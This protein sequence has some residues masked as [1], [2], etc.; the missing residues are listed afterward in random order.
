[1]ARLS[2]ERALEVIQEMDIPALRRKGSK[3]GLYGFYVHKDGV[4][5]KVQS[6]IQD[7]EGEYGY[8]NMLADTGL[9][10]YPYDLRAVNLGGEV[11]YAIFMEHIEG[12]TLR[13]TG[14]YDDMSADVAEGVINREANEKLAE[15]G[16]R[17][18][19]LHWENIIIEDASG[20][21]R[22]IDFTPKYIHPAGSTDGYVPAGG[23][24]E[25]EDE[26][27]EVDREPSYDVEFFPDTRS[28][29]MTFQFL[30]EIP[31]AVARRVK[32]LI[33]TRIFGCPVEQEIFNSEEWAKGVLEYRVDRKERQGRLFEEY[34]LTTIPA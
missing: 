16:I 4:G 24:D 8:L 30:A 25:D 19:D 9:T 21:Y 29:Q 31:K 34:E 20:E 22:V 28:D 23:S 27:Q 18:G 1:M 12:K 14:L 13:D 33:V 32:Y 10:P 7:A 2:Q 6:S 3:S 17:H 26:F 5:V 11:L 15:F